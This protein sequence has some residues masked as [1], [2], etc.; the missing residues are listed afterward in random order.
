MMSQISGPCCGSDIE[1]DQGKSLVW[2]SH[3]RQQI[4]VIWEDFFREKKQ[5]PAWFSMIYILKIIT[6][7]QDNVKHQKKLCRRVIIFL[8]WCQYCG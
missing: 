7:C 3:V 1:P 2:E 6:V 5:N 4:F 8:M